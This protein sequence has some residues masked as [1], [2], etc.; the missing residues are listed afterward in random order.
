MEKPAPRTVKLIIADS[1]K[2]IEL[3][4][5]KATEGSDAIDIRKIYQLADCFTFDPGFVSTA[6]C[7]SKIT[8][9][10]G[11]SGELRY[12]GYPVEQLAEHSSFEE[13]CCLILNGELPT[14][15][16]LSGFKKSLQDHA[17]LDEKAILQLLSSFDRSHHPMAM[18]MAGLTYLAALYH[19]QLD[20]HNSEYRE[21]VAHKVIAK[22]PTLIA[23]IFR[24]RKGQDFKP[25][26]PELSYASNFLQMSFD[27][28]DN[29]PAFLQKCA[30]A[31]D[32]ILIL[33]ADHE[34]NASTSTVRLSGSTEASPYAALVAGVSAL[35]GP[36]H[37]GANEAVI[38][39]L[40]SI[41]SSGESVDQYIQRA[42]DKEDHFKLMGFG[43][44]IYKNYDPRATI[45][46]ETCHS[47]LQDLGDDN[48]H[49]ALL[50]TAQALEKI[51]LQD[52]YFVK[53]KLYPNVDFYSGIIFK[54][55]NLPSEMF[56]VLFALARTV[57]WISHWNE[58][59]SDSN[60]RISRPRQLY[61]GPQ[62]R[63]YTPIEGR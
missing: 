29:D 16:K 49:K 61:R 3:P 8:Y 12:R 50:D 26:N 35:W 33:H 23:C 38:A 43:H 6:S 24:Y 54:A 28:D 60:S 31:L 36:A 58:M 47:L 34:Q 1:G 56:T 57:G 20:V 42:K 37:G 27:E 30:D 39:M 46:R 17:H 4:I 63:D 19:D 40:S 14:E 62:Q 32:L 2:E 45:I 22:V 52:E 41:V 13:V 18:L 15:Q 59:M 7:E 53:R 11:D 48:P 10:N 44:R 51:A 55:M 5:L 21:S 9:I 25:S